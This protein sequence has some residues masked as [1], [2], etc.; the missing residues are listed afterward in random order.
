MKQ[1]KFI[2]F[3]SMLL[4]VVSCDLT[5]PPAIEGVALEEM[6]GEW[7]VTFT[8][9]GEDI[10]GIGYNIITTYN[11]AANNTTEMWLDDLEHTWSFKLRTPV[12]P[13]TLSFGGSGLSEQYYDIT[14][15]V[16]NGVI[17]KGNTETT[18]GNMTD[19]I[20]FDVEFSDD[21]GTIY[22]V[23]GYRRTGFQEDEH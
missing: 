22:H 17:T 7:W 12:N 2:F 11:T 9:D 19:G 14:A 16:T 8:V 20:S 15:T 1:I 6:T 23:E 4:G 5:D 10:Y 3:L 21:A 13:E 18:G